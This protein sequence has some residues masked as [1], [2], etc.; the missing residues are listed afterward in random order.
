METGEKQRDVFMS[1]TALYRK[2]RPHEFEDVKG[3]DHIVTTLRIRSRQTVSDMHICSAEP[4][5]PVRRRLQR[6]LQKQS[7]VS[8]R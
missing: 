2:F 1:Y 5:E 7:T 3:Q 4:E 6:Y 8:I